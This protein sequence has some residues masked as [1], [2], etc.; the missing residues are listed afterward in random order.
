MYVRAEIFNLN[1]YNYLTYVDLQL[2]LLYTIAQF[3]FFIRTDS[4]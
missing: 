4:T 2:T 1:I 3:K